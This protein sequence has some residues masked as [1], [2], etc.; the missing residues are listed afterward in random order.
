MKQGSF[1]YHP[2]MPYIYLHELL[3]FYSTWIV[4]EGSL[5]Y[6]FWGGSKTM[7]ILWYFLGNFFVW[8]GSP[9]TPGEW[10]GS[11]LVAV[12]WR[13]VWYGIV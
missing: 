1:P 6:S 8:V 2:C 9:M 10:D 4:W 7:Q 5:N 13:M 12:G 3:N 11:P